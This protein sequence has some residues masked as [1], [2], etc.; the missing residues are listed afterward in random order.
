MLFLFEPQILFILFLGSLFFRKI[1]G[2][3]FLFISLAFVQ[4]YVSLFHFCPIETFIFRFDSMLLLLASSFIKLIV[5]FLIS[6][7]T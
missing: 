2:C 3:T 5:F 6:F 4:L 7:F 1:E